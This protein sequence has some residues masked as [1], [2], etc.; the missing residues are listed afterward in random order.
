MPG[1]FTFQAP[2][3]VAFGAGRLAGLG[4]DVERLAGA[5]ARVLIVTDPG[6]A[7]LAARAEAVLN[8]AGHAVETFSDVRSDPRA[9]SIDA[10]AARIREGSIGCVVGIGG[11]SALDVAKLAAAIASA[12]APAEHYGLGANPLPRKGVPRICVPTTAGTGSEVT[13]TSVFTDGAGRK[14]WA[15]GEALRADLA[16]LDPELTLGL[17]AHL[18]AATGIDALV[19]AIE[20]ATVRRANP[21]SDAPC[22]HAIRLLAGGA[23]ARAVAEPEDIEA[24]GTVLIAACLAGLGFDGT[25]TGIAHAM[26]HA[27]GALAGVHH[28]RAVGVCLDAALGWNAVAAPARHAAVARALGAHCDGLAETE[29][30][31]QAAP[32]YRTILDQVGLPLSLADTGLTPADAE[33]LAALTLAPENAPMCAANCRTV[34]EADA[35][36]LAE[37]LLAA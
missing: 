7:P 30:A 9:A 17:P 8:D 2:S 23:L 1:K 5:G 11:G 22:L 25:G 24:R 4:K 15:W 33:R 10:A 36:M 12:D 21:M 19:H 34:D 20:G 29:A 6:V 14:I 31:A 37:R 26:G 35:R 32:A 28:G 16:L 27:L 3:R 13:R 18:T